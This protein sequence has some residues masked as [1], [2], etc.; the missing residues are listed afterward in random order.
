MAY[1][2]TFQ[3]GPMGGNY[4]ISRDSVG[5]VWDFP[6]IS[7]PVIPASGV[8]IQSSGLYFTN[9]NR[10]S[11]Q[12]QARVDKEN[13]G[14][15]A[16][17][18]VTLGDGSYGYLYLDCTLN[19]SY[20]SGIS[21][22]ALRIRGNGTGGADG[23]CFSIRS[24]CYITLTVVWEYETSVWDRDGAVW[25]KSINWCRDGAVWRKSIQWQMDNGVWRRGI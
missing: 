16:G 19:P 17:P 11:N 21:S 8:V 13:V 7:G 12:R 10:T 20:Y 23:T 25:R 18:F 1:T 24:D 4:T 22:I 2:T 15:V 9:I 6:L 3:I 14:I 5:Y